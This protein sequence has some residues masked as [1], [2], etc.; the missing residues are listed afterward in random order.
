MAAGNLPHRFRLGAADLVTLIEKTRFAISSEET[1][2]YLN[3]IYVHAAN[4][5]Q[6]GEP[7]G[8]GDGR[9]SAGAIRT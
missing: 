7:E 5:G 4:S 2:F 8:G 1:R 9:A 6:S 3:G